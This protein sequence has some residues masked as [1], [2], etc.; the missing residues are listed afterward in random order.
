MEGGISGVIKNLPSVMKMMKDKNSTLYRQAVIDGI[1]DVD[2]VSKELRNLDFIEQ[3]FKLVGDANNL[4]EGLANAAKY[5]VKQFKGMTVDQMEKLYQL[6]D[7][8]FRMMI[9]MDRIKNKGMSRTE[10]ALDARKW[11]VDYDINAPLIKA[12]KRTTVPFISYTYRV[13]PLL[14]E[15]AALRPHKFAKW[16]ALGYALDQAGQYIQDDKIG[17]ELDRITQREDLSRKMF[18]A[19]P[20]IGDLMPNTN[21]RMPVNDKNGNALYWDVARWLP[22]GDIFE[23]RAT[24][25]GFPG[26]PG[27]FQP[28]GVYYD[29]LITLATKTDPFTGRELEDMGVDESDTGA[30]ISHYLKNQV[31]N[32]PGLGYFD[33]LPKSY[34]MKKYENAK[35]VDEGELDS[36]QVYGKKY[37]TKDTPHVGLAFMFGIRLRPQNVEINKMSRQATYERELNNAF[38]QIEKIEKSFRDGTITSRK[39]A[40]K[41]KAEWEKDIIKLNA[42]KEIYDYKIL[43]LESKL[44][45]Y[46]VDKTIENKRKNKFTGG[47]IAKEFPV[48]DV[49][50]N[51][52]Q[53]I[54]PF[55]NE[56]YLD[57]QMN[58]LGFFLGGLR[59]KEQKR[60][61]RI[62]AGMD[63]ERTTEEV[64]K[65]IVD[66]YIGKDKETWT[67]EDRNNWIRNL[68]KTKS[69]M[70]GDGTEEE[71]EAVLDYVKKLDEVKLAKT[72][73]EDSDEVIENLFNEEKFL[74]N[75]KV[76]NNP[77][78]IE[79]GQGFAGE[80]G[81]TYANNRDRPFVVMDSPI[82]GNRAVLRIFQTKLNRYKD[83]EDPIGYAIAEYLGG[84]EGTLE[85][86]IKKAAGENPN[87]QGYIDSVRLGYNQDGMKG[88]L[89]NVIKFESP[90]EEY[91][92][93]YLQDKYL[94]P[95]IPLAK[96]NFPEGT[97]TEEMLLSLKE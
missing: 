47:E 57:E 41:R 42:E 94:K 59:K 73:R 13:I 14:A 26:V 92:N 37:V 53:R 89:T 55:T 78:N 54:N 22:G 68:S 69:F 51:S 76:Y 39:E 31:P 49:K 45:Q 43:E 1:F 19:V 58:R 75:N 11:F 40:D 12:L 82:A 6:E 62:P 70:E 80:T 48:T 96:L 29:L 34:G 67:L 4:G 88:L 86:R 30:V 64:V 18:G 63:R 35:R 87:V 52:S 46:N 97:S 21:L 90:N 93:Y 5:R 28:G 16:G 33:I 44:S 71:K 50:E 60:I 32:L 74:A 56:P 23:Q 8:W 38:E 3:S 91:A 17:T 81:D 27:N 79:I 83:T 72:V 20:V 7:Q 2:M 77:G 15:A 24:G 9:Y 85:E 66:G 61:D 36:E 10:A 95:S 84:D 65:G 25:A